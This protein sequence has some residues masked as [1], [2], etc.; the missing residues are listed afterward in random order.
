[1]DTGAGLADVGALLVVHLPQRVRE[2]T[3][4]VDDALG[5]DVKL[6]PCNED[7]DDKDEVEDGED[8]E[9]LPGLGGRRWLAAGN[10]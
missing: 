7:Q 5:P 4:G 10:Y 6:L 1:M 3:S 8:D 9:T 2:R